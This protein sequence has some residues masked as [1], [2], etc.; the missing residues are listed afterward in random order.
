MINVNITKISDA[1]GK[2]ILASYSADGALIAAAFKD[3]ALTE[4]NLADS[5]DVELNTDGAAYITAFV[6]DTVT[7]MQPVS[8]KMRKDL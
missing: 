3:I 1:D 2:L 5:L 6:W 7:N 4:D 8:E